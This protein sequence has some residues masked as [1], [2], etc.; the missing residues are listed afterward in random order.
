MANPEFRKTMLIGL[1]G[2]GQQI[3]LRAKRLFLDTYGILPPAIKMLCLDTDSADLRLR[4]EI[5]NE[6]YRFE[7]DEYL[8][9]RLDQPA[10]FIQADPVVKKWFVEGTS[11]AAIRNGTGAVR[12]SGRVAFFYH[13]I[14]IAKRFREMFV[15]LNKVELVDLMGEARKR[16]GAK[17]DFTLSRQPP[18]IYVCGSLAGGTGSG[19]F[20][21]TGILLRHLQEDALIHG[22]FLLNWI[23][24]NVAFGHRTRGNTYA[25]FAELDYLQSVDFRAKGVAPYRMSYGDIKAEVTIPP[26]DLFHLIDGRNEVDENIDSIEDLCNTVA[27]AIFLSSSSMSYRVESAVDNLRTAISHT[28]PKLWDGRIARYSSVGV[29]CIHYP[30]KEHHNRISAQNALD[31]CRTAI[32]RARSSGHHREGGSGEVPTNLEDSVGNFMNNNQLQLAQVNSEICPDRAID[33]VRPVES[34]DLDDSSGFPGNLKTM[35]NTARERLERNLSAS[36]EASGKGFI[37]DKIRALEGRMRSNSEDTSY[38]SALEREWNSRLSDQLQTQLNVVTSKSARLAEDISG[39]QSTCDNLLTQAANAGGGPLGRIARARNRR[40]RV[41]QWKTNTDKLLDKIKQKK[42]LDYAQTLYESLLQRLSVADEVALPTRTDIE[43]AL[44]TTETKLRKI[45]Y[46]E[47]ENYKTLDRPNHILL[48]CGAVIVR[49]EGSESGSGRTDRDSEVTGRGGQGRSVGA[50]GSPHGRLAGDITDVFAEYEEFVKDKGI[51]N[52]EQYLR[53]Y[54]EDPDDL[55]N[56]FL[57]YCRDRHSYIAEYTV[58]DA[59]ETFGRDTG[60]RDAFLA[61]TFESLVR[62]SSAL[63]NFDVSRRTVPQELSMGKIVNLGFSDEEEGRRRYGKF[64]EAACAPYNI[65]WD[66]AYS[67]AGDPSKIWLLNFAAKIPACFHNGL[68]EAKESYEEQITPTYH[69]DKFLEMNVPDLFPQSD[70]DNRALRILGMSIVPGIDVIK[71]E[72]LDEGGHRFTC[73]HEK[74]RALNFGDPKVWYLFRDMYDEVR[75]S[76]NPAGGNSLLQILG[77]LLRDRVDEL[78]EADV[79]QA[80]KKYIPGLA[81]KLDERDFTRLIS[82]RLTYRELHELEDFLEPEGKGGYGMNTNRYVAGR[83]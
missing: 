68:K 43:K 25:A 23:Y 35:L 13:I 40:K 38:D 19:T 21:D 8:H 63:W 78:D 75:S 71:D 59:L 69:M 60:D 42:H 67:S 3:V 22:Y 62:R 39:I 65:R 1:G 80:I 61:K 54:Q 46:R 10:G 12:L 79:R 48:G 83:K 17:T 9:M 6:E 18:E 55:V 7:A 41:D 47:Q 73:S 2:A 82:A 45:V 27:N 30:A 15:D 44:I 24:R 20:I 5:S 77:G 72:K 36:F 70:A 76:H 16:L 33:G 57:A 31:L 56:L 81:E 52:P 37:A 53:I 34:F 58:D 4:S 74:V 50:E 49:R 28:E 29:S 26:Y 11:V 14:E 51:A 66:P 64:I 32:E